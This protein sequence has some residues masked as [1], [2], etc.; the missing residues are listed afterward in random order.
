M[1]LIGVAGKCGVM[2]TS[3]EQLMAGS[4]SIG[5]GARLG[6]MTSSLQEFVN[7]GTSIGLA[8]LMGTTSANLQILR[9]SIGKEGAIGLL[10]GL[11]AAKVE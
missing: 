4:V 3:L 1:S 10:I 11:M 7:G 6:V 2:T 9:R 5:V 8:M